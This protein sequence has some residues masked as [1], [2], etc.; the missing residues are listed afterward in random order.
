[1][2]NHHLKSNTAAYFPYTL[3]T[4]EY[5]YLNYI[6]KVKTSCNIYFCGVGLQRPF[7]T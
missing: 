1:M 4:F 2:C 5:T 3:N 7:T 6:F